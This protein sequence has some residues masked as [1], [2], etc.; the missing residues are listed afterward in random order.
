MCMSLNSSAKV[1]RMPSALFESS[2]PPFVTKA[3]T[4]RS[5]IRSEAHL[6][7]RM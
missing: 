7:A 4:P 5:A 3:T 2:Q 6:M 1:R